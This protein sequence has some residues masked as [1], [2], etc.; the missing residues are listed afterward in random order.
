MEPVNFDALTPEAIFAAAEAALGG[1]FSGVLMPL[2]SY[3]NRV[4]EVE[5]F[6]DRQRFILKFYRPGRWSSR[7]LVEEHLFTLECR[8]AEIPAVT[9]LRLNTGGTLGMT[10]EGFRFA[11]FPKRW[12]RILEAESDDVWPRLG[13]LLARL[14]NVG[15]QRNAPARL[16][17]DPRETTLRESARLLCSGVA[18]PA[19]AGPLESVLK[20]LLDALFRRWRPS[21]PIRLHGDCHKGNVLERPDEGLML[22]DFDDMLTGPPVQDLWLL[23][24]GPPD[25]CRRELELLLEGYGQ[26]RR[27]DLA[28]LDQIELLR[29]MRMIYFLDWCG[30]QRGDANFLE[31]YPDW[32]SDTFWRGETAQLEEQ[33][34]RIL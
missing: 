23:L 18:S 20:R 1:R 22:I 12:G 15:E 7:A 34:C 13:A 9:P 31:R 21:V 25:E 26:F 16:R 2:H 14:H 28:S 30:R 29:A 4:Y 33:L 3:I 8:A 27:F 6:D 32:G 19:V 10:P 5:R 11:A 24:P 17:L